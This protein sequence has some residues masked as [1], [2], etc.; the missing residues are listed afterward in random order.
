MNPAHSS[1]TYDAPTTKVL[2]GAF[3]FEKISSEVIP[4][5]LSPGIPGYEGLPPQAII[6]LSAVTIY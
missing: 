6:I 5:S 3:F 2:P 1:A 4:N